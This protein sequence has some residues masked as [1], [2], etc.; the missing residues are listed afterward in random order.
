MELNYQVDDFHATIYYGQTLSEL[1]KQLPVHDQLIIFTTP[2]L[3]ER[4]AEKMTQWYDDR[5][6][7]YIIPQ[8]LYRNNLEE[9]TQIVN[10]LTPFNMQ[11]KMVWIAFGSESVVSLSSFLS[12]H[13]QYQITLY[14]IH[15]TLQS[16]VAALYPQKEL[17]MRQNEVVLHTQMV[18]K[19]IGY[20]QLDFVYTVAERMID[21]A[22]GLKYGCLV[23]RDLL[24]HLMK[25]YH[26]SDQFETIPMTPFLDTIV[27]KTSEHARA[28]QTYER[29]FERAF[30]QTEQGHLLSANMKRFLGVFFHILWDLLELNEYELSN[31]L[32]LWLK[33]L[34][35]PVNL[36][37]SF[38]FADYLIQVKTL[39]A[40][41]SVVWRLESVGTLHQVK[42]ETAL[43]QFDA[44][45]E[46]YQQELKEY[47]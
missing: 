16:F 25:T 38:S 1:R 19:R 10:F 15:H 47:K 2:K 6:T 23:D 18:P 40:K 32:F 29:V 7:F 24:M 14:T 46:Y 11:K 28:L 21:L 3:Y 22:I 4:F 36:P 27:L 44:L 30:Y 37:I 12:I 33:K 20:V 26:T 17:V 35:Y 5:L 41:E 45:F 39:L 42:I 43:N 9:M 13:S 31:A 34:G 8:A